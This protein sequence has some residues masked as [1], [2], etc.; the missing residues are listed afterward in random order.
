MRQEQ[1]CATLKRARYRQFPCIAH[2]TIYNNQPIRTLTITTQRSPEKTHDHS[3]AKQ[4]TTS[5]NANSLKGNARNGGIGG[6]SDVAASTEAARS[7]SM[8]SRD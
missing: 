6:R 5:Q 8:L 2:T 4:G 1:G 3:V 7:R